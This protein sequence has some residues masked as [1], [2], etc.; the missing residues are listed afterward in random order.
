MNKSEVKG[1]NFLRYKILCEPSVSNESIAIFYQ[2][3]SKYAAKMKKRVARLAY[4]KYGWDYTS[5]KLPVEF[6][7]ECFNLDRNY[8]RQLALELGEMDY[9]GNPLVEVD[10]DL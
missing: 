6:F 4:D 2:V 3:N 1:I 9:D 5:H 8:Y 10:Y 7:L